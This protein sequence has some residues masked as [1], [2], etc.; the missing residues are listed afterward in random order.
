VLLAL[1]I[2]RLV[3]VAVNVAEGTVIV[4]VAEVLPVPRRVEPHAGKRHARAHDDGVVTSPMRGTVVA[5]EVTEGTA[6]QEGSV[7]CTIEA[8]K[9]ELESARRTTA[10][11][12]RSRR[13]RAS[14][15]P[16]A[17]C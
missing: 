2:V 13:D 7:L 9:M 8:M 14:A 5:L 3:V 11:C 12:P 15:L 16:P 4:K 1:L 10:S 6:V 17:R